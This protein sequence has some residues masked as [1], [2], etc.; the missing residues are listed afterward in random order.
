MEI[1]E[2]TKVSEIA[3]D[4][5]CVYEWM[6]EQMKKRIGLP[7]LSDA[8]WQFGAEQLLLIKLNLPR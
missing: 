2:R 8:N 5:G 6:E 7:P 1:V 4:N 3:I